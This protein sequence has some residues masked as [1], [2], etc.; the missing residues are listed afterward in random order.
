MPY[1]WAAG[2]SQTGILQFFHKGEAFGVFK[3]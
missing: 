1:A 2:A 3:S